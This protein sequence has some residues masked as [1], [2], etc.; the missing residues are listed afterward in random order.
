M[1]FLLVNPIVI[2]V[3]ATLALAGMTMLSNSALA[4]TGNITDT[5]VKEYQLITKWGSLGT[6][7][8]FN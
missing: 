1:I 3:V 5:D 4:Q 8:R 7:L 6:E 2:V